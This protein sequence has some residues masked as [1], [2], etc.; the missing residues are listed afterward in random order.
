MFCSWGSWLHLKR[1]LTSWLLCA[2]CFPSLSAEYVRDKHTYIH[3]H[4][5]TLVRESAG[6]HWHLLDH[7]EKN[8]LPKSTHT[9]PPLPTPPHWANHFLSSLSP[10]DHLSLH[11]SLLYSLFLSPPLFPLT[12]SLSLSFCPS[13]CLGCFTIYSFSILCLPAQPRC[14]E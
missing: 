10:S 14:S 6:D 7:R 9:Q 2:I 12:P 8:R 4:V 5:H 13:S 11:L 1:P 3:I